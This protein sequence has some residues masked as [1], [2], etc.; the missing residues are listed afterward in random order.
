MSCDDIAIRV[1]TLSKRYEIYDAP[2]DRLKQFL[3][4]RLLRM[5]RSTPK[6]YF[7]EFWALQNVS[8]EV[9]KG[10]TV[11]IIGRNGSGKSS[12]L[13]MIC[14][15]LNPT[16]GSIETN[17]RIAALLELGS[18]FNPEF[19]G[20]ENV[21]MNGAVLGL[22][23]D[24][25]DARF[26]DI[27]AFADIGEFIEQPVKTY[28]SGMGLRLAFAVIAYV[29]A[30]ILIIDEALAVGDTFFQQKCMRFLH[31]FQKHGGSVLFV[32][33]DTSAVVSLCDRAI[34]LA[35][36]SVRY[37]G[38]TEQA[39]KLLLEDLYADPSRH[40]AVDGLDNAALQHRS[41]SE[42]DS[43]KDRIHVFEGVMGQD[44]H[45]VVSEFRSNAE[46]FG[47]GK[48]TIIDAGFI[49]N[50]NRK[51]SALKGGQTVDF[52]IRVDIHN[53]VKH[54]AFGLM[55]K[56]VLG[57][58][59]FTEGTDLHFRHHDLLFKKGD[60]ATAI[61]TFTMPHLSKGTYMMN[62]AF[63]EGQGD[64]HIQHCWLHDAI[65]LDVISSRLAHGYCGMNDIS[66]TVEVV[67]PEQ[68]ECQ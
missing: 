16:F 56:N 66:M 5:A 38:D 8:F 33:H 64:S 29:E 11:G 50:A 7:G 6:Q 27:V 47:K 2:I 1:T 32:S 23:K 15:T 42:D 60:L 36:G 37:F 53:P 67:S 41:E 21:Y 45:Y 49:E 22:S 51:I 18:G 35:A 39:T 30:D 48:A 24:E 58:Y 26:E 65:Q 3:F 17:G 31:D 59:V 28:S 43:D 68:I 4:P 12:L 40:G 14:G 34:L 46:R 44:T 63:A 55:I 57:E 10:E 25:I 54:P 20:R 52:F 61:F 13:Q 9:K 62:V 19:T